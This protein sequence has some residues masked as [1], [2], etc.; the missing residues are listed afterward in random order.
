[1][2]GTWVHQR[3][4]PAAH[5]SVHRPLSECIAPL[6]IRSGPARLEARTFRTLI[7][8]T[9]LGGPAQSLAFIVLA[10]GLTLQTT[11]SLTLGT[12]LLIISHRETLKLRTLVQEYTSYNT[13]QVF[14]YHIGGCPARGYSGSKTS[15]FEGIRRVSCRVL[16]HRR[17]SSRIDTSPGH[18]AQ[19]TEH[20][21]RT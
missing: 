20:A 13:V 7:P 19:R 5:R 16:P 10:E 6:I 21:F 14:P 2:P 8:I 12:V 11:V 15:H 9:G 3:T 17:L 1:M 18:A 4:Y